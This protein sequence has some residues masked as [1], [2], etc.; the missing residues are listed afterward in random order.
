MTYLVVD[1]FKAGGTAL[2]VFA[3]RGE[4]VLQTSM[5]CYIDVSCFIQNNLIVVT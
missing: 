5:E 1:G 2:A 3:G 4:G